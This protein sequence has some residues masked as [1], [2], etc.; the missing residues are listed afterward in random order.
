MRN[1][2]SSGLSKITISSLRRLLRCASLADLL[3]K[4]GPSRRPAAFGGSGRDAEQRDAL[5]DS[6]GRDIAELKELCFDRYAFVDR[7][8]GLKRLKLRDFA[9]ASK[10]RVGRSKEQPQP[11][12]QSRRN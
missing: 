6:H 4:P 11:G 7:R 10:H 1:P 3:K 5:L 2:I 8:R 12:F 9:H